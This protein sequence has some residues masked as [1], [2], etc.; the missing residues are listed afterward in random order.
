MILLGEQE[1]IRQIFTGQLTGRVKNS[2]FTQRPARV[3]IPGRE[4]CRFCPDKAVAIP[5]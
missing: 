3:F 1:Y 2:S 5:R 4:E